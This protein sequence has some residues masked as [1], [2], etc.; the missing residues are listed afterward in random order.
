METQIH[1]NNS[2]GNGIAFLF[3]VMFNLMTNVHDPRT[4]SYLL[5]A[6]AGGLIC[7][8]FKMLGDLF[9]PGLKSLGEKLKRWINK[10]Y[11]R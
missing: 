8:F 4:T 2:A 6:V 3:G 7:L 11:F 10:K 1:P 9:T 5:H